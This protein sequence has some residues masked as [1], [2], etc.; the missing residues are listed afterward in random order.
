MSESERECVCEREM[1]G[2]LRDISASDLTDVTL[3][4]HTHTYAQP[5]THTHT[6][7]HTCTHKYY[8]QINTE[9]WR[10]ISASDRA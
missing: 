9:T 4:T 5:H 2:T 8:T 10:D 3:H 7:T 1:H 6:H